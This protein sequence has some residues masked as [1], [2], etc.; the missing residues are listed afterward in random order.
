MVDS[1]LM[2]EDLKKEADTNTGERKGKTKIFSKK[3]RNE[4][5][6]YK[7]YAVKVSGISFHTTTDN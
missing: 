7:V 2:T 5:D 1:S 6:A 3:N 4:M